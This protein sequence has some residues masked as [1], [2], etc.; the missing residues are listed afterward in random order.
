MTRGAGLTI[1]AVQLFVGIMILVTL[2]SPL[3]EKITER[4]KPKPLSGN[5]SR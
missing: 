5:E 4:K 2:V 1:G 3:I